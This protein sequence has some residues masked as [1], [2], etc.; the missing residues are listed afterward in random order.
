MVYLVE[1][2][3]LL[4]DVQKQVLCGDA[5]LEEV[6]IGHRST[7]VHLGVPIIW[8]EHIRSVPEGEIP[9]DGIIL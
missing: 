4:R 8:T 2:S 7:S 1:A 3:P 9:L 5:P 6:D